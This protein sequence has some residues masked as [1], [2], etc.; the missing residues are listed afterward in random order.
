M[1]NNEFSKKMEELGWSDDY[2]NEL[3][4]L[5]DEATKEGIIIPF[6]MYLFEAPTI[7]PAERDI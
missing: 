4:R 3:I 5:S 1:T 7:Y 6:E 2:I